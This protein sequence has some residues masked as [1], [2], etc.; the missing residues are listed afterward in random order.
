MTYSTTILADSP[1][2]YWRLGEPSGATATDELGN[3]NGTY[4]GASYGQTGALTGDSNTAIGFSDTY[5]SVADVV[6]ARIGDVFSVECWFKRTA[7]QGTAQNIIDRGSTGGDSVSIFFDTANN[8]RAASSA[9]STAWANTSAIT[10]TASWHHLV[11]TK[12][13]T[14]RKIWLDGADATNLGTNR[15]LGTSTSTYRIGHTVSSGDPLSA[16]LDE[17]AIYNVALTSGQVAAHYAAAT[18]VT[19]VWTTPADTVSMSTTPDLKFTS[20]GS[21]SKQHFYMELDTVN[22]FN[23]GALRTYRSDQDQT[24]WTY[25]DGSAWQ[26]MPSDGLPIA[27]SGNE[28]DYTITSTLSATTWYRR[29]RAGTLV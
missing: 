29:V 2:A 16:T 9:S 8:L 4:S 21:A 24:N 1:V 12:D 11:V 28:V 10:D 23:S 22:T 7:T 20:P 19:P 3:S 27:K 13:G 14:A 25:Y 18:V 26:A 15:T 17:V 5:V 6:G